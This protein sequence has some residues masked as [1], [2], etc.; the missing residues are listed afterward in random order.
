MPTPLGTRLRNLREAKN[1]TLQ[2]VADAAS[3]T[4]AYIWELEM[5]DGQK[6]SAERI[7]SISKLL[8]VTVEDLMG[9]SPIGPE[10]TG[11]DLHF[12]RE[13][14]GMTEDEKDRYRQAMA[15]MFKKPGAAA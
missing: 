3:C 6:P 9:E 7:I 5:R 14:V 12:F 10:A 11:E 8:G 15:I 4:R 13:Y 1:L 2:Q